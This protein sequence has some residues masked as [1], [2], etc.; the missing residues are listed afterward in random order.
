M[1]EVENSRSF[2]LVWRNIALLVDLHFTQ[3][4]LEC[5][6]D[7]VV[8]RLCRLYWK[9]YSE[10]RR[11]ICHMGSYSVSSTRHGWMRHAIIPARLNL[12][13]RENEMLV[14]VC[15]GFIPRWFTC[16][17]IVTH[18][19]SDHLIATQPGVEPTTS[20]SQV[21]HPNRYT[22]KPLGRW[23]SRL[24]PFG[25]GHFTSFVLEAFLLVT[26][27]RTGSLFIHAVAVDEVVNSIVV[28]SWLTLTA[29]THWSTGAWSVPRAC[30]G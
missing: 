13:T 5:V 7:S 9:P 20:R 12:P 17:R 3:A 29:G 14:G 2:L 27:T 11:I 19:S 24:S 22:T 8:C 10:L 15:V 4:V 23:A 1:S 26:C 25:Y 30:L 21:Q 6:A 18:L 16:P 28:V